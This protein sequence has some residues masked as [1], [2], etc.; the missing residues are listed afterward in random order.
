MR[1]NKNQKEA[2]ET[3]NGPLLI[4]AGPGSGKTKTLVERMIY[5][6]KK[7]NIKPEN[8]LITTFTE[9]AAGELITR[10]S[11][12]LKTDNIH[13]E[14]MYIGTL[15]SICLKIIDRYIEK[16]NLQK[17]YQVLDKSDQKFF[18]FSKF[19][20]F[21]EIS[22][23]NKFFHK[24][25]YFS[26]WRA[27][28]V[29]IEW[30]N[31]FSEEGINTK[32]NGFLSEAY[33]L[34]KNL[35][36]QNNVID[37]SMIQCETYRILS[38]NIVILDDFQSQIKYLMIDEYQ[39]TNT[40]QEKLIFLIGGKSKNI[41]VVG[42]DDQGI[43]RFRGATIQNILQ[44]PERVE[45]SC[46][47]IK[48]EINYR[49]EKD[50]VMFCEK[51]IESLYW[52]DFR[53]KKTLQVPSEKN[54]EKVRVVTLSVDGSEK[55]WQ[56]R[57]IKFLKFLKKL[58]IIEDYNQ[59]VFLFRSVR[60]RRVISLIYALEY[61]EIGVYSPRSNL[62]FQR[63]EIKLVIGIFLSVL[64]R[65]N[66]R[67]YNDKK[68][69]IDDY[70]KICLSKIIKL[71]YKD[72]LFKK[73][74]ENI[75]S[76]YINILD[77]VGNLLNL[78]YE[79]ISMKIFNS[80][81]KTDSD[82]Y[83]SRTLYNLGIFSKIVKKADMISKIKGITERNIVK[84]GDYFF[85]IHL[86]FIKE[87]GI[88]EYEDI[89]EY[90]PRGC[91]S[92][93]TIHQSKGLEF[94]VVI[95]DSLDAEPYILKENMS[96][97]EK[98]YGLYNYFEPEY[99]IPE[100]DF[101]R[102]YYTAFSRAKNLL[103]LS[104]IENKKGKRVVPSLPFKHL[105][106]NLPDI[107][108]CGLNFS[109][110]E[111]DKIENIDIKPSYSYTATVLKYLECPYKYK[112]NKIYEFQSKKEIQNFY[113][114]L[115]HENLEVINKKIKDNII[116]DKNYIELNYMKIYDEMKQNEGIE[117]DE[118]S[119]NSGLEQLQ[120]YYKSSLKNCKFL[121]VEKDLYVMKDRYVIEG[122]LD[123]I[124][125]DSDGIKI[126]DFKTGVDD[127]DNFN[128]QIYKNQIKLY[129]YLVYENLKIKPSGGA[130]YF[131]KTGKQ[132]EISYDIGDEKNILQLFEKIDSSISQQK[133]PKREYSE[134][135]C[136]KCEFKPHCFSII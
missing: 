17:G 62:Y 52:N 64:L 41:C 107:L 101:W 119:L 3:I 124:I 118:K 93:M 92:F 46:K 37:F 44:F 111:I 30:F 113:G 87:S 71:K 102:L 34:Y 94:P 78:F 56:D 43:Y 116:I 114:T 19:K 5:M 36:F 82:F 123:L 126:I 2:V 74:I 63:E 89:R 38:S 48:L 42:D 40:I 79:I 68:T 66:S 4:I 25:E 130:I 61:N 99:R 15:H 103:I 53:Y 72:S 83:N 69:D 7:K 33:E 109:E 86:K 47:I 27:G 73:E 59:V 125:N 91:V 131:L 120:K 13:L 75:E 80:I 135:Y 100:F 24:K 22:G 76:K 35:L 112:F 90:A 23:Y 96:E 115:I 28:K 6:I 134:K 122:K 45:N 12:R 85:M 70:Y 81:L 49:S 105:Y 97:L 31:R 117:L 95:V 121:Y 26:S 57:I 104:C 29:L 32:A 39:D 9:R 16:S 1:L 108:S 51:W 106:N 8:I 18:I 58:N 55:K 67:F 98:K 50:I 10:V 110:L 11:N 127:I 77:K 14:N 132:I 136:A 88:D 20:K 128:L 54:N 65:K 84:I 60:N 21:K 133:F 129:C